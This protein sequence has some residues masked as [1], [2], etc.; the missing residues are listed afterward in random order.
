MYLQLAEP[1]RAQSRTH[2]FN[3]N[4]REAVKRAFYVPIHKDGRVMHVREDLLDDLSEQEF[5]DVLNEAEELECMLCDG[6]TYLGDK[7]SRQAKKQARQ[8]RRTQ[9]KATKDEKAQLKNER[10]KA[11]N[12]VILAKADKKRAQGEAKKIKAEKKGEGGGTWI[13]DVVDVAGAVG[14]VVGAFKGNSP[15]EPAVE[16]DEM[17]GELTTGN[18]AGI[19][20][21]LAKKSKTPLYIGIGAG[22]LLLVGVIVLATRK[23]H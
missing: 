19:T 11:K 16:Q 14:G 12:E 22:A 4:N 20:G 21:E 17:T 9:R 13:D 23:K 10:K 6:G 3:I 2:K 8:E 15:S 5:E 1:R 18:R 7:A